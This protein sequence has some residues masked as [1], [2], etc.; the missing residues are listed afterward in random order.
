MKTPFYKMHGAG[1]D[2]VVVDD[3]AM[4]FPVDDR[5]FLA[6]VG[7]R[8]TGIGCDGFLL[9]QPSDSADLRMRFLNPDGNEQDMC[10]NGARCFARLAYDLGAAP[11]QMTIET[12]AGVVRAAVLGDL[13]RLDLTAPTDWRF[14]LDAGWD[15]SVDFVN[16]GVEHAVVRVDD[17]EAVD[18]AGLGRMLRHHPLFAPKGA[19]ANFVKV[20]AC[21]TLSVRTY[22]RGVE[23]ETLAC[24]TG[25]T[26]SALVAARNGWVSLPVSVQVASGDWLEIG[27][28][29]TA[30]GAERVTL[31]GPAVYVFE[32][33]LTR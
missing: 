25:V 32:G 24:G 7:A 18:V 12:R 10:G 16:T 33:I 22:E 19:N 5:D 17:V 13:I 15:V 31:T 23:A 21:A 2:F 28:V 11:A 9:L 14:G 1:N 27:G 26:A 8:R 20:E 4:T 29:L 6:K 30:E 3:R